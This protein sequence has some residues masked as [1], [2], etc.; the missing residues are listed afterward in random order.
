MKMNPWF[1]ASLAILAVWFI[2]YCTQKQ[3][4]KKMWL[5]SCIS[6]P[7]GL[8]E[9][10]FVPEYW[11]PPSLFDLAARFGFDIESIIF[12][13][14]VGGIA[15]VV[16]EVIF[17]KTLVKT[18]QERT[19]FWW[20]VVL[21]PLSFFPSLLFFPGI[22]AVL[23]GMVVSAV[24]VMLCRQDL[25]KK[26]LWGGVCMFIFYSI[27]FYGTTIVYPGIVE[28]YWNLSNLWGIFFLGLP[29]EELVYG[30]TLGMLWSGYY[31][32]LFGYTIK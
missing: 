26:M 1:A 7:L 18:T 4:R 21:S 9:F 29:L 20:L 13:F 16:Y 3:V 10:L 23:A 8:T 5:V 32:T 14:A 11:T 30:F 6:A 31:E 19:P 25:I 24:L 28:Q 27:F 17:Q 15:A 12:S 2:I 22:Y